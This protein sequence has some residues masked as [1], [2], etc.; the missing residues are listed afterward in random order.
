MTQ[1]SRAALKAFF[2]TGDKPTQQQFADLIDS[3]FSLTDDTPIGDN[4]IGTLS[5]NLNTGSVQNITLPSGTWLVSDVVLY[6]P[7]GD[8]YAAAGACLY[9][10][11]GLT[12]MI[13]STNYISERLIGLDQ[14]DSL[15]NLNNMD[16]S[17][18]QH[19]V[20]GTIYFAMDAPNQ[21]PFTCE[22]KVYGKQ[23]A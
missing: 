12:K 20:S 23:L 21:Q 8:Y 4:L 13:C 22:I 9:A 19:S 17:G 16:T 10:D 15:L 3:L 5:A 18:N 7:V 11:A 1:R 14:S 6:N 2:E